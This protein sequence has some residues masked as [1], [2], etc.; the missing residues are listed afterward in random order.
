[1]LEPG[2][3]LVTSDGNYGEY[4]IGGKKAIIYANQQWDLSVQDETNMP[5]QFQII[6]AYPNPFLKHRLR[7]NWTWIG[8]LQV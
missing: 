6:K 8:Q 1:M 3:D 2:N 7:S 4:S 5:D